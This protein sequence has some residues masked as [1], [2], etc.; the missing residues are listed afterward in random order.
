MSL[1]KGARDPVC[2]MVV[3]IEETTPRFQYKGIDYYFCS[4]HC[5]AVFSGNPTAFISEEDK[6][7]M[8]GKN[9]DQ[10]GHHDHGEHHQGHCGRHHHDQKHQSCRNHQ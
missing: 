3:Q 7:C 10:V 2:E 5:L 8:E 4:G 6:C 1:V 9:S